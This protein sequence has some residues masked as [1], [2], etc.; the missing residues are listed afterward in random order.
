MGQSLQ[1]SLRL[2]EMHL[3]RLDRTSPRLLRPGLSV[4]AIRVA[5]ARQ[6]LQ[7]FDDLVQLYSWHD[8]TD[9][10]TGAV[11]GDLWLVPG[12][13]LSTLDEALRNHA[14]FTSSSGWPASWLPI[15]ANGGGDF[16][17]VDASPASQTGGSVRHFRIEEAEH[18]VEYPGIAD[19]VVTFEAAFRQGAF[20]VDSAG[21]LEMND[22][23]YASLAASLNPSV[24][25][26]AD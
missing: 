22:E 2:I 19:M 15:L 25:W 8:G 1:D 9:V 24:R 12:F 5:L 21:D 26:W 18:P 6:G 3:R 10:S 4:D 7:P 14:A 13:Y 23:A 11:L 17:V 16:L 20:F